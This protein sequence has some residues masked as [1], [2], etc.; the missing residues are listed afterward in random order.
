MSWYESKCKFDG[1]DCKSNQ[2]WNKNKCWCE[3]KNGKHL[4]RII[5]DLVVTCNE[6]ENSERSDKVTKTNYNKNYFGKFSWKK[7]F[8]KANISIFCLPFY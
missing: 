8:C 1:R 3:C 2:K 4:R 6:I 5:D 7:V